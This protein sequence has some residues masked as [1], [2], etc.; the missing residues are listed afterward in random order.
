MRKSRESTVIPSSRL[1]IEADVSYR[2]Q[3]MDSRVLFVQTT[4]L[5]C[6]SMQLAQLGKEGLPPSTARPPMDEMSGRGLRV[7]VSA[8]RRQQKVDHSRPIARGV[9]Q[10]AYTLPS[11]SEGRSAVPTLR[12]E[13]KYLAATCQSRQACS[14]FP[15]NSTISTRPVNGPGTLG[16][17]TATIN[18]PTYL[19]TL[20]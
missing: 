7:W 17:R 18:L 15:Q 3:A 14:P 20:V 10:E 2:E 5:Q 6:M 13:Y 16:P 12:D 19:R 1:M 8:E 11:C 9:G 4:C